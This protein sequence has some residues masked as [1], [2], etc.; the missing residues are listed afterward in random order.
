MVYSIICNGEHWQAVCSKEPQCLKKGS[1]LLQSYGKKD[2]KGGA[3][4]GKVGKNVFPA[5]PKGPSLQH[6]ADYPMSDA[7]SAHSSEHSIRGGYSQDWAFSDYFLVL[8][9]K[10]SGWWPR[11]GCSC[12]AVSTQSSGRFRHSG[13]DRDS[14][15]TE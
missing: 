1:A 7:G 11:D 15:H 5:T 2:P 13:C 9:D 3:S 4:K 14:Q 6:S 10:S 8:G 12:C